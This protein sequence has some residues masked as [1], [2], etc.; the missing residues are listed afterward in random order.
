[1]PKTFLKL[2]S[3]MESRLCD[4]G[5]QFLHWLSHCSLPAHVSS[6]IPACAISQLLSGRQ[7]ASGG[8]TG[9]GQ[10]PP[11]VIDP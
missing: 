3:L 2:S 4:P 7:P 9:T 8:A 6:K 11:V 1:M 5:P 10:A